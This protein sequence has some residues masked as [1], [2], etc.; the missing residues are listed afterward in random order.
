MRQDENA[1]PHEAAWPK[2]D[3]VSSCTDISRRQSTII[4]GAD[5]RA[6]PHRPDHLGVPSGSAVAERSPSRIASRFWR[7]HHA[8]IEFLF[9]KDRA[10]VASLS[11]HRGLAGVQRAL[12]GMTRTSEEARSQGRSD[13][14]RRAGLRALPRDPPRRRRLRHRRTRH[15]RACMPNE[16]MRPSDVSE[17]VAFFASDAR[18]S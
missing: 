5:L 11:S 18:E 3:V 4:H 6:A 7:S 10:S 9:W 16:L 14:Q 12:P 8:C 1:S 13:H 2:R 15:R 17:V